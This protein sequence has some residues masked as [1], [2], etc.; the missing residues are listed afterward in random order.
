LA[1]GYV[2]TLLF[3]LL[4]IRHMS[5]AFVLLGPAI[6]GA[7]A[8]VGDLCESFIKRAFDRKDSGSLLP[9]HGGFMDRLMGSS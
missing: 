5:W 6:V 1:G 9:G 2:V 4:V 8:Q 7:T 3:K